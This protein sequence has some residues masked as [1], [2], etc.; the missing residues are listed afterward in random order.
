M[1]GPNPMHRMS[2]P[3]SPIEVQFNIERVLGPVIERVVAATPKKADVMLSWQEA[4]YVDALLWAIDKEPAA[5]IDPAAVKRLRMHLLQ[6]M[7]RV[8]DIVLNHAGCVLLIAVA[9][10]QAKRGHRLPKFGPEG[11]A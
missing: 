9:A 2:R 1:S 5:G 6:S 7:M 3:P 8:G 11:H 10:E 4:A